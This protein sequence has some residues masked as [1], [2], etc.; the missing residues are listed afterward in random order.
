MYELRI[1]YTKYFQIFHKNEPPPHTR[2][3]QNHHDRSDIS[4][5]SPYSRYHKNYYFIFLVIFEKVQ[6]WL[7]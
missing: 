6:A 7:Q 3:A 2:R 5:P 1:I 4:S